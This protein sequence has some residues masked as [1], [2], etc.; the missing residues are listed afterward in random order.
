[1]SGYL[2]WWQSPKNTL[3]SQDNLTIAEVQPKLSK[4][5][6][7]E[8]PL[9]KSTDFLEEFVVIST[10]ETKEKP[11]F[12]L[13]FRIQK[14][15]VE[16]LVK[17]QIMQLWFAP[18]DLQETLS[19]DEFT[20]NFIP[21]YRFKITTSTSVQLKIG[22]SKN[23]EGSI[24]WQDVNE[25]FSHE[26]K[27][28]VSCATMS[29]GDV[30]GEL[31]KDLIKDHSFSL[32]EFKIFPDE[33]ELQTVEGHD[34]QLEDCIVFK[35]N[36]LPVE[37]FSSVETKIANREQT[38]CVELIKK[39][40]NPLYG[41]KDIKI[42]LSYRKRESFVILAPVYFGHFYYQKQPYEVAVSGYNGKAKLKRPLGAG[43][44]GKHLYSGYTY[45]W[46]VLQSFTGH[47]PSN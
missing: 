44:V 1:M 14:K 40:Y 6:L 36:V 28:F 13:P 3:H 2:N 19:F 11:E 23:S 25:Q 47:T 43:W 20:A 30:F 45:A 39:K 33:H 34:K 12:L 10:F 42:E 21:Y 17:H 26:Y 9:D 16:A 46:D 15:S 7:E 5:E 27:D 31:V 24:V 35:I 32:F 22:T 4:R 37:A 38:T 18:S 29:M 41:I 8:I